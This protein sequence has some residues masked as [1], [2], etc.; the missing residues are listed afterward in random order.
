MIFSKDQG[1]FRDP[2]GFIFEHDKRIIRIIKKFGKKNYEYINSKNI[3]EE[4]IN[5]NFLIKTKD[6]TSE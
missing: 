1:S 5:N 6:V 4:S 3:I 2:S